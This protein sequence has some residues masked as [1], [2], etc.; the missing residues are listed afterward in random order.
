M[1]PQLGRTIVRVRFDL[2]AT[3][4]SR[5]IILVVAM[6]YTSNHSR[7]PVDAHEAVDVY[8]KKKK[9]IRRKDITP[10]AL[11]LEKNTFAAPESVHRS[12]LQSFFFIQHVTV[13]LKRGK[14]GDRKKERYRYALHGHSR[15]LSGLEYHLAAPIAVP[16]D[17]TLIVNLYEGER[18]LDVLPPEGERE[19]R[20]T[21][22]HNS[23]E[24][25]DESVWLPG[26]ALQGKET[27]ARLRCRT[28]AATKTKR[29]RCRRTAN[30][31]TLMKMPW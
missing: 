23:N 7:T 20:A 14:K 4:A 1:K 15:L 28:D 18:E 27:R 10:I 9:M 5:G 31:A 6:R 12:E 17:G 8:P 19:C 24:G 25:E 26:G 11:D 16:S 22:Q 29:T 2:M 13:P 3:T 30:K 21:P